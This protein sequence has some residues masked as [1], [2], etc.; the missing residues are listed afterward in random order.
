MPAAASTS[1]VITGADI[2]RYT[3]RSCHGPEGAGSPKE[4]PSFVDFVQG[5]SPAL[6]AARMK[7]QGHP[8]DPSLM[9]QLA[10]TGQK[11][12][13]DRLHEGGKQ[14]PPF[15]YLN[16][17]ERDAVVAYVK[18]L[19]HVP[20]DEWRSKELKEPALRV[21][22]LVANGTC[23][24]CHDA[25]GP[26]NPHLTMMRGLVPSLASFTI[27]YEASDLVAKAQQGKAP[28][29]MM[30]GG[31]NAMPKFPYLSAQELN[32]VQTYLKVVAPQPEDRWPA[33]QTDREPP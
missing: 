5:T 21:G 29:P 11:A 27:A 20:A 30:R 15:A 18:Q 24:L 33:L 22:E 25:T 4:I 8:A 19:S 28:M 3:C 10:Q 9:G 7:A 6:L 26:G 32:A 13:E 14:M 17:N 1:F 31:P 23:H 2:Y 16:Q 12:L